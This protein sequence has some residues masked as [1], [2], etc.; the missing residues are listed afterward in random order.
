MLA[1]AAPS[2]VEGSVL[3]SSTGSLQLAPWFLGPP[4]E[5][6]GHRSRLQGTSQFH[7]ASLAGAAQAQST[8]G[9]LLI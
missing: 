1:K 2:T 3:S 9:S 7:T 4:V 6:D 8:C 5:Q